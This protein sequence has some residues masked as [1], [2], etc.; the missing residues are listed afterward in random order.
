MLI[1]KKAIKAVFFLFLLMS[2]PSSIYSDNGLQPQGYVNINNGD[3]ENGKDNYNCSL[4]KKVCKKQTNL[5]Y[6][7]FIEDFINSFI[8][9]PTSNVSADSTT[10]SSKYL[11]GRAPIYNQKNKQ[12]GNCSASFLCMQNG[13]GIFTDISNYLTV[14]NGLIVSWFTPT[15]LINLE[16]DSIIH[17]MVTQCLV[18][19]STKVGFNPFYGKTYNMIVSSDD[20]KIYFKLYESINY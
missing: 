14:D 10:I 2:V 19:A 4:E 1:F 9:I 17:S 11:A 20:K 16:L 15:T 5:S 18:V 7:L 13:D 3:V 12:V 6:Y 8:E